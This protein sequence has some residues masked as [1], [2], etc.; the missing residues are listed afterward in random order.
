MRITISCT[1]L[2]IFICTLSSCE[3]CVPTILCPYKNPQYFS[4][5]NGD[6]LVIGFPNVF[7]PND[8]GIN[9]RYEIFSRGVTDVLYSIYNPL[10]TNIANFGGL[11]L[12]DGTING[13]P[14]DIGIYA[15]K[16]TAK[17][18]SGEK[19][20]LSG[21]VSIIGGEFQGDKSR[22]ADGSFYWEVHNS[23][24]PVQFA[25][26]AIFN[27]YRPNGEYAITSEVHNC[28]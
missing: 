1:L 19:I 6:T 26:S 18:P 9:D 15:V 21:T 5:Q 8:D 22:S 23:Q 17:T 11:Q 12:W 16:V 14:A 7:T 2:L 10:G 28:H 13:K 3:R 25:Y 4:V 27:L 24:F 20:R